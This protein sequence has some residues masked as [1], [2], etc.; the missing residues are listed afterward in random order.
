MYVNLN[1]FTGPTLVFSVM[2]LLFA[3]FGT[4]ASA[5]GFRG[6]FRSFGRGIR[7]SM[8]ARRSSSSFPRGFSWGGRSSSSGFRTVGRRGIGSIG[9]STLFSSERT[10]MS[11]ADRQLY[12][13]AR[14]RGTAF[15]TRSEA[16][17]AFKR[18]YQG[19]YRNQFSSR[20]TS[21]PAYIPEYYTGPNGSRYSVTYRPDLG[22]Y[23]YYNSSLGRWMLYSVL[24]DAVMTNLLMRNNG[25]YYGQQPVYPGS[26][27]GVSISTGF[28]IFLV[29]IGIAATRMV[30]IRKGC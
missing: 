19:Q 16:L 29:L 22:G 21:R 7:F 27:G 23:G 18:K 4:Q 28:I 10:A 1:K 17:D 24:G 14:T 6:G 13:Q 15:T 8:P 3:A 20:P 11:K 5:R 12:E 2:L 25:Y 30:N 9:R 26:G